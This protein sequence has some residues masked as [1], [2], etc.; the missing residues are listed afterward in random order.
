[1]ERK[2]ADIL[3]VGAGAAGCALAHLLLQ[4]GL[5]VSLIE[6]E[7]AESKDKLCGGVLLQKAL[8]AL[9]HIYGKNVPDAPRT[10][11]MDG[12]RVL[13]RDMERTLP[14][15]FVS[16]PR[17][18]LDTFLLGKAVEAGA[19][20]MERTTITEV[21]ERSHVVTVRNAD[22]GELSQIEYNT[23]V[24]ADGADSTVRRLLQGRRPRTVIS[25]QS[26]TGCPHGETRLVQ[27]VYRGVAGGCWLIPQ[28]EGAVIGCLFFP[29]VSHEDVGDQRLLL[30]DFADELGC[31]LEQLRGAPVPA[32][33]DVLLRTEGGTFLI[34]DAAGLIE[35]ALGAGLH[36]AFRS[37]QALAIELTG[38]ERYE[39]A[40]ASD[41]EDQR[42][43]MCNVASEY[44]LLGASV[45]IG[46]TPLSKTDQ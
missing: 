39:D 21:D 13:Y 42:E 31:E 15:K 24:A 43:D 36:H 38:G 20:L 1:M 16:L 10:F 35:P 12:M 14:M 11:A 44:L 34:G 6:R 37:A 46:N 45:L 18:R 30:R 2:S 40:M 22:T 19:Q 7:R 26:K 17:K 41:L 8:V 25:F 33:D 4:A 23:L 5:D 3:V 27:R 9:Q 32:G 28:G 29:D